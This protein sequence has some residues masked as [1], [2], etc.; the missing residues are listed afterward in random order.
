MADFDLDLLIREIGPF[1]KYQL[2]NYLLLCVPI[3][4]STMFTLTYVF[5]AGDLSYRCKIPA[6]DSDASVL[7][8]HQSS[9]LNFTVPEEGSGKW[10]KCQRYQFISSSDGQCRP[11]NFN[12][13]AVEQCDEFVYQSDEQTIL[14]SFDLTC[15]QEWKLSFVGTINN[16]G[17][18]VCLPLT[19][20]ISDRYGRKTVFVL[21]ILAS[22]LLGFIRG[23][24]INFPMFA[25]FEFL[26]PAFGS[27]VYSSGFIL[28]ENEEDITS[29]NY[30]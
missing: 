9:F 19:G 10:S 6:C 12:R 3:A 7:N 23:F 13:D 16:I 26:E 24:S 14:S 8:P 27:A 1:G 17:Q 4:F 18:F 20:Y 22:G 28:G 21:G 2:I 30:N 5:T 15:D 11:E 25:I 29:R